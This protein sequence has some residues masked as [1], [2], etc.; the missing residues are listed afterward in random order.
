MSKK[1][2]FDW[3]QFLTDWNAQATAVLIPSLRR[4]GIAESYEGGRRDALEET[5][6]AYGVKLPEGLFQSLGER[7][8][9]HEILAEARRRV[10][11][12]VAL[13]NPAIHKRWPELDYFAEDY[14]W[15]VIR[16]GGHLFPPATDAEITAVEQR[17]GMTLPPSYKA[18]LR[19]SN[20]WLT[21]SSRIL[22]AEQLAWLRDK[23]PDWVG[24]WGDESLDDCPEALRDHGI[25]GRQQDP[26]RYR[27]AYLKE[28]LEISG[29]IAEPNCVFL[30]NPSLVFETGECEAWFLAAWLPG[31]HRFQAFHEVMEWMKMT[32]LAELR[33]C[34]AKRRPL[35]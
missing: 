13:L 18:F 9:D 8:S 33:R 28:C 29:P 21:I 20:G 17:L 31:A 26:A 25:Y 22:P 23:S 2:P 34:M 3:H 11:E 6:Q 30:L 15:S 14:Y 12:V 19:E 10:E 35:R 27:R 1:D 7:G 4:D 16:N 5:A 24:N 32:D